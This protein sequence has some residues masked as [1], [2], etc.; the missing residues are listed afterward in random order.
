MSDSASPWTAEYQAPLSFTISISV[1]WNSCPLSQWW[2]SNHLILCHPLLLFPSIFPR[3]RVFSNESALCIRW[4]RYQSFRFSISPSSEYPGLISVCTE[5]LDLL[6]VQG[7][8]KSCLPFSPPGDRVL[9][10]LFTMTHLS[11]VA[12]PRH[13]L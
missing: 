3:I 7:T 11:W 1:C 9:S 8:L 2:P 5:W 6:A 4:P 13:G 10:Q 12:Q